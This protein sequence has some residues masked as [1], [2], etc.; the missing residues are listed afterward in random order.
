[1]GYMALGLLRDKEILRSTWSLGA[2][3]VRRSYGLHGPWVLERRD[4]H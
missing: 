3:E 4:R 2:S 1:M